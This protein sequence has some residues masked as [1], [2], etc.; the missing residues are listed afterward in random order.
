[1]KINTFTKNIMN[2]KMK[3]LVLLSISFVYSQTGL[4]IAR[5]LDEKKSPKDMESTLTMKLV[6]SKGKSRISSMKSISMDNNDKQIIWFLAPADDKGVSFLKIEH[7]G[8]DDEIRMWLP[9]FKKI[10]R[11]S[12][13]KKGDSFMGS[14]LSYEDMTSR[15]LDDYSWERKPDEKIADELYYVLE[16]KPKPDLHSSYSRHISWIRQ[17]DLTVKKEESYDR[18]NTL[19][20]TKSLLYQKLKNYD[21]PVEILVKNVLKKHSTLLKFENV[22]VDTGIKENLFQE[23]NLKRMPR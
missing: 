15:D 10:R 21:I 11:I 14:D 1:V 19:I 9:A 12:S 3:L 2:I 13:Q 23:K 20:K 6:N 22:D 4:E 17:K 5:M 18:T 7:V 8:K 16:A